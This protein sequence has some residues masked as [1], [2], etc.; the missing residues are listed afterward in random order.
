MCACPKCYS[1]DVVC[2]DKTIR[3]LQCKSRSLNLINNVEQNKIKLNIIDIYEKEFQLIVNIQK[4]RD[5]LE[6]CDH[7]ELSQKDL[8]EEE[9]ILLV[10]SL[11]KVCIV[12][13]SK[14]NHINTIS[15]NHINN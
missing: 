9:N 13:N 5:L 4:I 11:V 15:I 1:N 7:K 2:S 12:F 3:C 14:N 8:I 6:E 10:L